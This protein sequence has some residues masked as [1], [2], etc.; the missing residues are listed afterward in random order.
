MDLVTLATGA[1]SLLVPYLAKAGRTIAD[2]VG[3]DVWDIVNTKV[4][5]LYESIKNKFTG[6]DY[7]GQTLKRL[8]EKPEDEDRQNAMKSIL[9]ENLAED[10]QFQE[11]VGQLLAETKQV[12]GD[13]VIRVYGSGAAA[14]HGGVAAGE[15]G[16]AAGRDINIG[17]SPP[18][19]RG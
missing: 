11:V 5:T 9:K 2:K 1:V 13:S 14:A 6:N 18:K 17:S 4:E 15:G 7:A 12:G 10:P 8:E 19:D 16:Y 3:K